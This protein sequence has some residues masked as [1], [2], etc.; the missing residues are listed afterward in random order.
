MTVKFKHLLLVFTLLFPALASSSIFDF[1]RTQNAIQVPFDNS[2]N[3]FVSDEVQ[4]AIE[5]VNDKIIDVASP[6]YVF[7]KS[8][9]VK[10]A[11]L[12]VGIV[13]SN[14]T[15]INFGFFNGILSSMTVANQNVNTFDVQLFEHDGTVFTLLTTISLVAVRADEF[16]ATDFGVINVTKGKELAVKVSTGTGKNVIVTVQISGTLTP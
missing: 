4:S 2:T 12:S 11:W 8:G 1:E 5:E 16:D 10:N 3:S 15:G 14:V 13:P 6:G 7:T 9:T